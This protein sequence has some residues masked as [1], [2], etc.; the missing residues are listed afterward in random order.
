MLRAQSLSLTNN[1]WKSVVANILLLWLA[2]GYGLAQT[3][4]PP[5]PIAGNC[6]MQLGGP[7]IF[8][9]TFDI[10]KDPTIQSRTGDLDPNVWGVSRATSNVNFAVGSLFSFILGIGLYGSVYVIP[11]YLAEVRGYNSLQIGEVMFVTG[12]FQMLSAPLAGAL[13]KK[14]DLRLMLAIGLALFGTGVYLTSFMTAEWGFG[15]L[16]LPQALRGS[17]LM[18]CFLPINTLALGTLPPD[19]LKNASGL[20]NLMRNL[21][22]AIGLA[23]INTVLTE[24][25]QFHWNRLAADINPGHAGVRGF[26]DTLSARL[27]NLIPGDPDLAA[28]K[29]LAQMVYRQALVLTF[30]DVLLLMAAV[31]GVALLL[32][33]LVRKPQLAGSVDAH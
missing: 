23:A 24:R 5:P 33:P 15:E 7:V 10:K 25:Q 2:G 29:Q 4:V 6:G 21:G 31:F 9:D 13:S 17:S 22:G 3:E 28:M 20:Y 19:K 11:L 27:G 8:C 32:M 16:L 1:H 14:L 26:L 18:L 12:F 30:N